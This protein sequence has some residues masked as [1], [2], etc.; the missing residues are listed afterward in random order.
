MAKGDMDFVMDIIYP[1]QDGKIF[2][3]GCE[4]GWGWEKFNDSMTKLAYV[5]QDQDSNYHDM[6]V[7]VVKEQTGALEVIFDEASGYIDHE[8][9]GTASE[10][11]TNKESLRQFIFNK[12]SWL[13]IGNDNTYPDPMFYN[14][15]E[16]KGG[17]QILPKYK[18][19]LVIDNLEKTTKYK[20][21]PNDEE[22]EQGIDALLENAY[23]TEKGNFI[24]EDNILFQLSRPRNF[25]RKTF[26]LKQDY[27]KKEIFFLRENDDRFR[28]LENEVDKD[29]KMNY[30]DRYTLMTKKALEIPGLVK[31][32]KFELKEISEKDSTI[33]K[34]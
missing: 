11:C 26:Y 21:E 30:F 33:P 18:F 1:D 25:Y 20:D 29:K 5:F 8:G 34:R 17:R 22:L 7:D 3:F 15:P 28:E 10:A 16:F 12:N 13:F 9:C 19:E 27:S 23:L 6:I 4:F 32:V 2:V 24:V 31:I 14:V